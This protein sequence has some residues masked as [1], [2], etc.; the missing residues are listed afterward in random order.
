MGILEVLQ[1]LKI[2]FWLT[3]VSFIVLL[4]IGIPLSLAVKKNDYSR[5]IFMWINIP[6]NCICIPI[7]FLYYYLV[8]FAFGVVTVS[9]F[10]IVVSAMIFAYLL[11]L[12]S[13]YNVSFSFVKNILY[14]S[15]GLLS[16]LF[17][18]SFVSMILVLSDGLEITMK[19][20]AVGL[21]TPSI[22]LLL[23]T[24]ILLLVIEIGRV[25]IRELMK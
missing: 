3:I 10:L 19:L 4:T 18:W 23:I 1:G 8:H 24:F 11:Y 21:V 20:T 17:K 12:P 22:F 13:K 9:R 25:L 15:L 14:N 2:N 5:K 7:F 16:I 6:F